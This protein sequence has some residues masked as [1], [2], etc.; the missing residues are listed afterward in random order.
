MSCKELKRVEG[1]R[2]QV[3][4]PQDELFFRIDADAMTGVSGEA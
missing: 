2:Y 4:T 1:G 3:V